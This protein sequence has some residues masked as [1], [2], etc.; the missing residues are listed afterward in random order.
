MNKGLN[1]G[2]EEGL[3]E[4]LEKGLQQEARLVL[5]QLRKRVG[6]LDERTQARIEAM[7]TERLEELGEALLDFSTPDDLAIWLQDHSE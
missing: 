5:R 4:G 7:S 3:E 6:E 1:K 2:R